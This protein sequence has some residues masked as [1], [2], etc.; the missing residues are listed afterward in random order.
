MRI[1]PDGPDPSN[2]QE[3]INAARAATTTT[4]LMAVRARRRRALAPAPLP[5]TGGGRRTG[6]RSTS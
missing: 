6:P 4:V 2:P 3:L 5:A 1:T